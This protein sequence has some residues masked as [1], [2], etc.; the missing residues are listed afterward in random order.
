MRQSRSTPSIVT[1]SYIC[2]HPFP[3]AGMTDSNLPGSGPGS[4]SSITVPDMSAFGLP[5]SFGGAKFSETDA[6]APQSGSGSTSQGHTR[7]RGRGRGS[8]NHDNSSRG[9]QRGGRGRGRGRGA[10]GPPPHSMSSSRPLDQGWGGRVQQQHDGGETSLAR[11]RIPQV[12][13]MAGGLRCKGVHQML[14]S[15]C[16]LPRRDSLSLRFLKTLGLIS[17]RMLDKRMH[18]VPIML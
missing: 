13:V 3:Q 6:G 12:S 5:S 14:T 4:G 8:H 7:G 16:C 1:C 9:G 17:P 11:Q 18:G 15:Q 2:L 10:G